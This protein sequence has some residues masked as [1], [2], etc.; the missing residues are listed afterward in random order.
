MTRAGAIFRA[1]EAIDD[2]NRTYYEGLEKRLEGQEKTEY[3][4]LKSEVIRKNKKTW[5]KA[6]IG[7]LVG[8]CVIASCSFWMVK[9]FS[10]TNRRTKE[11]ISIKDSQKTSDAISL[12]EY[13][14]VRSP[15]LNYAW[16]SLLGGNV[17]CAVSY[18]AGQTLMDRRGKVLADYLES[19]TK[20]EEE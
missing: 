5:R 14:E 15:Y 16:M 3:E 11:R 13:K 4:S 9:G 20:Q 7:G 6:E 17:I 1:M 10:D 2:M 19:H 18:I 8:I 12:N